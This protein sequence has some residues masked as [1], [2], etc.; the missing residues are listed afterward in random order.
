MPLVN[1]RN[2]Y[3]IGHFCTV[4]FALK[5]FFQYYCL[6]VFLV[7]FFPQIFFKQWPT[8]CSTSRLCLMHFSSF[9]FFIFFL[10]HGP[11][12]KFCSTFYRWIFLLKYSKKCFLKA[13]RMIFCHLDYLKECKIANTN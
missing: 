4:I 6:F 10:L 12:T 1:G 3:N 8:L 9:S 11:W 13:A 7:V 2:G 5:C